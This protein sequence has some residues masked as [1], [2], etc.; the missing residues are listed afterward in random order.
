MP[1]PCDMALEIQR[2]EDELAKM[3]LL[4]AA[5][6]ATIETL[7]GK[8]IGATHDAKEWMTRYHI[9]KESHEQILKEYRRTVSDSDED[10]REP[11]D[12]G[13]M[14]EQALTVMVALVERD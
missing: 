8:L 12:V 1:S 10:Y 7:E 13:K 14:L 5:K 9:E 6:D 11:I 2:L 3:R 4:V